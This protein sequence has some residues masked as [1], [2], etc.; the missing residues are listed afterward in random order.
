MIPYLFAFGLS[1]L[2]AYSFGQRYFDT[3]SLNKQ[4][5]MA[6]MVCMPVVLLA[7]IR[8]YTIG[9]DVLVYGKSSYDLARS[10]SLLSFIQFTFDEF[11]VGYTVFTWIISN[12]FGSLPVLLGFIELAAFFPIVF[13]CLRLSTKNAWVGVCVFLFIFYGGTLNYLRQGMALGFVLLSVALFIEGKTPSSLVVYLVSICMHQT[14]ILAV[15]LYI[16]WISYRCLSRCGDTLSTH[17][18]FLINGAACLASIV[19]VVLGRDLV[20]LFS[21]LKESYG[22]QVSRLGSGGISFGITFLLLLLLIILYMHSKSQ[23]CR[24]SLTSEY[25]TLTTVIGFLLRFLTVWQPQLERVA[26]FYLAFLA[27]GV[28]VVASKLEGKDRRLFISSTILISFAYFYM[29]YVYFGYSEICPFIFNPQ[30]F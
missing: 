10:C 14:A 17:G 11:G 23:D 30:L 13:A 26:L 27:L 9:T 25:F 7:T 3:D 15:P 24:S 12:A 6:L 16:L 28:T 19:V 22:A 8:D 4:A 18:R 2:A 29:Y 21:S 20:L 1:T 5:I